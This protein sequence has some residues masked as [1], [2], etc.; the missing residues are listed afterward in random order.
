MSRLSL[1]QFPEDFY[2]GAATA[3]YQV[4]GAWNEG[5]AAHPSG[6]PMR[7]PPEISVTVTT[8]MSLVTATIGMRK[9][10]LI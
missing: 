2:W 4:E 6:I 9:I 8:G 7:I 10:L 1:I 3:A 5:A